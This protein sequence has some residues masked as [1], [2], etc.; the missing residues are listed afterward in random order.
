MLS[1]GATRDVELKQKTQQLEQA[2]AALIA[3]ENELNK[4]E[5]SKSGS[6]STIS[7]L[8]IDLQKTQ[9]KNKQQKD[10]S[11]AIIES[12]TSGTDKA[13]FS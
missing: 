11:T 12:L 13:R 9:E 3:L 7:H 4:M 5:S 10:E 2:R 8:Q 6:D 1:N